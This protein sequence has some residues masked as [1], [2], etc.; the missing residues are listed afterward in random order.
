M[1][2]IERLKTG[3]FNNMSQEEQA[4]G[5]VIVTL[6]KRGDP[7]VYKMKVKNLYGKE[8]EVDWEKV[9]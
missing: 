1:K 2:V 5:S 4:D 3:D 8:E 9:E 7:L 6:T